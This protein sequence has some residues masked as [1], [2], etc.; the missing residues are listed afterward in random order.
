[1]TQFLGI[2]DLSWRG[3]LRGWRYRFVPASQVLHDNAAST[4]SGSPLQLFYT[5]R[6]RLLMLVKCAPASLAARARYS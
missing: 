5:E 3:Q 2:V 1:M 4:G 6:N